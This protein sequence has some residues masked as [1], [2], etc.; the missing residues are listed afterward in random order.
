LEIELTTD[1][2]SGVVVETFPGGV[3]QVITNLF[4]NSIKHGFENGTK[5]GRIHLELRKQ[6]RGFRLE[7]TDDGKGATQEVLSH[8][9]DPFFTTTRGAGG[10]GLGMHIVY[11]ILA[12]KL[13]WTIQVESEPNKGFRAIIQPSS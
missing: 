9:F 7:I 12:Q 8:I 4:M 10:S 1:L 5:S 11:N 3:A 2:A 13:N 6:K